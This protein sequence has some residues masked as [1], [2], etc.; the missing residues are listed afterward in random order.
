MTHVS[1]RAVPN[2]RLPRDRD[3]DHVADTA[4]DADDVRP[5]AVYAY[6]Q[7]GVAAANGEDLDTC[8]ELIA[9]AGMTCE[10]H[11]G[12]GDDYQSYCNLECGFNMYDAT[13]DTGEGTNGDCDNLIALGLTCADSFDVGGTYEGYCDFS[14]EFCSQPGPPPPPASGSPGPAA[15]SVARPRN[16]PGPVVSYRYR[17]RPGQA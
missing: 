1:L 5:A 17:S 8:A 6:D 14:C 4:P 9:N 15:T 2:L 7:P 3:V 11:F 10:D 12:F 13:Q 16:K